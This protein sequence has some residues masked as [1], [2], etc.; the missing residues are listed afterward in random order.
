MRKSK[1][2]K[3]CNAW[4]LREESFCQEHQFRF[5]ALMIPLLSLLPLLF[6]YC[7]LVC[8]LVCWFVSFVVFVLVVLVLLVFAIMITTTITHSLTLQTPFTKTL[9]FYCYNRTTWWSFMQW[10]TMWTLAFWAVSNNSRKFMRNRYW[11]VESQ[12]VQ[13]R[14]RLVLLVGWVC[15]CLFLSTFRFL[16]L[17]CSSFF[18]F[19]SLI[20]VFSNFYFILL[21]FYPHHSPLHTTTTTTTT[22][23]SRQIALSEINPNHGRFHLET[24]QWNQ[25]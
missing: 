25:Q 16:S 1:R 12:I 4:K 8:L 17:S 20:F 21:T 11:E 6:L 5:V 24:H 23:A 7:F 22:T 10:L 15:L 3:Q 19:L 9:N 2:H 14:K 13:M 18:L